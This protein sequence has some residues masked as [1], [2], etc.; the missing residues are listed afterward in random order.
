MSKAK[1]QLHSSS[2]EKKTS[3]GSIY[4]LP[5]T[6]VSSD[7]QAKEG[8]GLDSQELRCK[9]YIQ[10]L[11]YTL[12][13]TFSDTASGGGDYNKREGVNE[14]I[15]YIDQYPHRMF[16]VVV[17]DL[18][19]IARD[20]KAY[21][22]LKESLKNRGVE[23]KSPN[24][25]F[26]DSPEGEY[27]ET[28][29]AAGNDLHRKVN[30]R[31]VIQKQKA[32]LDAGYWSF[33]PKRGYIHIKDPKHGKLAV[34]S[35]DGLEILKPAL[36]AFANGTF[37]RQIDLCRHLVEK[38]FWKTR[39]PKKYIYVLSLILR[40]PF[41]TG[42]IEYRAWEVERRKGQHEGLISL[43]TFDLIQKRIRKEEMGTRIRID[44]RPE[45]PQRGLM[46]CDHCG[47]HLTAGLSR[48]R[49]G[50]RYGYYVCHNGD[51]PFYGK[52]IKTEE[53]EKQFNTLL[54]QNTLKATVGKLVQAVFD[55]VWDQEVDSLKQ[56]SVKA[57]QD[58]TELKVKARELTDLIIRARTEAM[59]R[60]YE[61]QAEDVANQLEGFGGSAVEIDL[62]IPYRTALDKSIGLL[63]KPHVV[64]EK[65]SPQ[66]QQQL[67]YFIFEQKLRY[68]QET[69]Y[70]TA[71]IPHA[72][73]LFEEFAAG[74]TNDVEMGEVESPSETEPDNTLQV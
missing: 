21:L 13:P 25:N 57:Q 64:W 15:K 74:N 47:D 34:P 71:Q 33:G 32:R 26:D 5:Y 44:I 59:R 72:T 20:T 66:E 4:A 8:H 24:F 6:R 22:A 62:A 29:T 60:M 40:D 58:E 18:S 63:K 36:E 41:Y 48:G 37:V 69:G 67:F 10:S 46:L 51:C 16:V 55:K 27:I 73:R 7:R 1:K 53:V 12:G 49:K 31:Q 38:G 61:T 23:F 56:Q 3:P 68:N 30:R 9:Q 17:D 65:L 42:D 70:R 35:K 52:S 54:K 2:F 39:S 28:I 11:G 43:E 45:F 50:K 14:L 19:R